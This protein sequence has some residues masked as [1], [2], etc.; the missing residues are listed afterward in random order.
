MIKQE[1]T[2]QMIQITFPDNF[3]ERFKS[4]TIYSFPAAGAAGT[5]ENGSQ[6]VPLLLFLLPGFGFSGGLGG[7]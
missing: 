6:E 2:I 7:F 3:P 5:S 1:T 4:I